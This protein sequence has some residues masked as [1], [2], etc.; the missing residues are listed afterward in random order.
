MT[1][2]LKTAQVAAFKAELETLLDQLKMEVAEEQANRS[3]KPRAKEVHDSGD[4]ADSTVKLMLNLE[5]LAHY[6]EEIADCMAALKRIETDEFGFCTECG[7]EIELS[8]LNACPTAARC[9]RCQT[10]HE[11]QFQQRS[12]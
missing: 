11:G 5:T 8:R 4:D 3:A 10:A 6:N 7:E 1:A 9:I 2:D 12:A